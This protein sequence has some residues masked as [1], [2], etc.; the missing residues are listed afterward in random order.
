MRADLRELVVPDVQCEASFRIEPAAH[1]LQ[2]GVALPQNP[3]QFGEHRVVT[4]M[5]R[6]ENLVE[7]RRAPS[8]F[9]A[10]NGAP[11]IARLSVTVARSCLLTA[12]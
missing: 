4:G 10:F 8:G 2:Q 7:V 1:L 11:L 3:F 5:Q 12:L 6:D 9:R